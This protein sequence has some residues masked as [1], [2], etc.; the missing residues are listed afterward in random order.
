MVVVTLLQIGLLGSSCRGHLDVAVTDFVNA[1]ARIS[2]LDLL[3]PS[4]AAALSPAHHR[5]IGRPVCINVLFTI[6]RIWRDVHSLYTNL[7]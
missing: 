3:S 4:D 2:H 6:C 7:Q 1:S 5:G